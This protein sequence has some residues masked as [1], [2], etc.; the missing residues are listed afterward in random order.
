[1][2]RRWSWSTCCACGFRNAKTILQFQ[3]YASWE[4][5]M[6]GSS[7]DVL[8]YCLAF[9]STSLM[10]NLSPLPWHPP[11]SITKGKISWVSASHAFEYDCWLLS[12]ALFAAYPLYFYALLITLVDRV[13]MVVKS[14]K[15]C[16]L[17]FWK[18]LTTK[19][20][21]RLFSISPSG[22]IIVVMFA[23]LHILKISFSAASYP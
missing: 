2:I 8:K 20:G 21:L 18:L 17:L 22:S 10:K 4:R 23:W 7:S 9:F 1:M 6:R 16:L 3:L 11:N 12:S 5:Y 13:A 19:S 15:S 14:S